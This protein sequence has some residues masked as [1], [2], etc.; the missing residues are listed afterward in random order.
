MRRRSSS[1]PSARQHRHYR[2]IDT[3]RRRSP[4][5]SPSTRSKGW[6]RVPRLRLDRQRPEERERGITIAIAH[7]E[8]ETAN[9]HYAHV[10]CLATRLHQEHDHGARRWTARSSSSPRRRPMP[11]RAS[12]SCSPRWRCRT[13]SSSSTSATP[14]TI[15]SCSIRR[16]RG[17]RAAHK[18]HFRRRHPDRPRLLS[19]PSRPRAAS[20]IRP[21]PASRS[22]RCGRLLHPDPERPSTSPS[23]CDR[24][25]F[26]IKGAAPCHRAHRARIVK[27]SDEV[28]IV[29]IRPTR[30]SS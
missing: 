4:R 23:S 1:G 25:C 22:S 26:G 17:S 6:G 8:Y 28:E 21:T 14:S 16:A 13:S 30:K 27:V 24:R 2:H 20:T 9:R 15:P 18:N 10:D 29:G 19:R 3:A 5:R 12:T 11:R 7:V